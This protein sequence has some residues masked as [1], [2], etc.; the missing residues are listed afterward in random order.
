MITDVVLL[1]L[2]PLLVRDLQYVGFDEGIFTASS[3]NT[4]FSLSKPSK[5]ILASSSS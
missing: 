3:V 2:D 5:A 4:Y 1:E